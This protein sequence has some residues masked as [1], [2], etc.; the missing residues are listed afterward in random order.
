MRNGKKLSPSEVANRPLIGFL[1]ASQTPHVHVQA[2]LADGSVG[3]FLKGP[4][5]DPTIVLNGDH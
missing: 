3:G 4:L 5:V 2:R 1:G